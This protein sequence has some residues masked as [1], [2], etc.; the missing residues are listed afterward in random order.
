MRK[1][2]ITIRDLSEIRDEIDVIDRQILELFEKR[3][4]LTSEVAEYKIAVGK[5]VLDREREAEKLNRLS[6]QARKEENRQAVVSLFETIMALSRQQQTTII[7]EK[8]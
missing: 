5:P 3:M 6:A 7:T 4:E 1:G 2:R 8:E